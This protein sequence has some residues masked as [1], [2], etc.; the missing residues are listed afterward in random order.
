[1]AR[2]IPERADLGE[3]VL[4]EVRGLLDGGHAGHDVGVLRL[5]D[6]AGDVEA[7]E[8]ARVAVRLQGLLGD[9][10]RARQAARRTA[11]EDLGTGRRAGDHEQVAGGGGQV[12]R[13]GAAEA[14]LCARGA[15]DVEEVTHR[16]PL[17]A[18]DGPAPRPDR[19][20]F[21]AG[22]GAGPRRGGLSSTAVRF[23]SMASPRP[24]GRLLELGH[25]CARAC[26]P[27]GRA[28]ALS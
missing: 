21:V 25:A 4:V 13:G 27:A 1:M 9:G 16:R 8:Q 19:V 2:A 14:V 7:H 24:P 11:E 5:A 10:G 6:Y 23:A 3:D 12:R 20:G 26:P 28:F 22:G 17:T 15:R 18:P